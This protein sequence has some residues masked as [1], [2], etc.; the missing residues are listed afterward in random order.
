MCLVAQ[1]CPTLCDPVDCSPPKSSVHGDSPGKKTEVGDHVLLPGDLPNPGIE[2]RSPPLQADSLPPEI[3]G[4]PEKQE[5]DDKTQDRLG[6]GKALCDILSL[7]ALRLA[8]GILSLISAF[9]SVSII[10]SF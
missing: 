8:K 10:C 3:P 2:P 9:F 7:C 5:Y 1:L 6:L 4:K